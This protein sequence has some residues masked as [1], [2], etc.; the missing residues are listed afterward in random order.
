VPGPRLRA[1]ILLIALAGAQLLTVTA[2]LAGESCACDEQMCVHHPGDKH[3]SSHRHSAAAPV[4]PD[5]EQPAAAH[6]A[7][8]AAAPAQRECSMR[9]CDQHDQDLLPTQPPASLPDLTTV[10]GADAVSA[11]TAFIARSPFDRASTVEPPPPRSF[12]A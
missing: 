8:A 2:A 1:A 12:P 4:T 5:H 7:H 11:L 6:C 9:G 10:A 3:S